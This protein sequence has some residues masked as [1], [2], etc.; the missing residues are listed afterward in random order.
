MNKSLMVSVSDSWGIGAELNNPTG[1]IYVDH[2]QKKLGFDEILNLADSGISNDSI[3]ERVVTGVIESK[4]SFSFDKVFVL[5]GWTSPE[6]RLFKFIDKGTGHDILTDFN[7]IPGTPAQS[8]TGK[9]T[10]QEDLFLSEDIKRI[11]EYFKSYNKY[12]WSI[13]ESLDRWS[14]QMVTL[15]RFLMSYNI[16]HLF[17]NNFYPYDSMY[18]FFK[19]FNDDKVTQR[20]IDDYFGYDNPME[21]ADIKLF[22]EPIKSGDKLKFN[23]KQQKLISVIPEKYIYPNTM[24]NVLRSKYQDKEPPSMYLSSIKANNPALCE[25]SH[26][27]EFGH[28]VIADILYEHIKK[29]GMC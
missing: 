27:N 18:N 21:S 12:F 25:G 6:R 19:D 10:I 29:H 24:L 5:V 20:D 16:E 7:Y 3:Y 4:D 22:S 9:L 15:H 23:E 14:Y 2:L 28:K 13:K 26:P 1:N 11:Q 8:V 17:F